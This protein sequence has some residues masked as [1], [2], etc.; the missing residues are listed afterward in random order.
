MTRLDA[1][2]FIR[3]STRID[4]DDHPFWQIG[5]VPNAAGDWFAMTGRKSVLVPLFDPDSSQSANMLLFDTDQRPEWIELCEIVEYG[6]E[7]AG[8]QSGDRHHPSEDFCGQFEIGARADTF[9]RRMLKVAFEVPVD[10]DERRD[11]AEVRAMSVERRRALSE[12]AII[13]TGAAIRKALGPSGA[14]VWEDDHALT[15]A[16]VDHRSPDRI[17]EG[18]HHLLDRPCVKDFV[19]FSFGRLLQV[20]QVGLSWIATWIDDTLRRR[21]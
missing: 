21:L 13:E 20:D 18:L 10:G 4:G 6:G 5:C 3:A 11:T 12:R 2:A 14:S 16:F 8:K 19:L 15:I 7:S 1:I 17:V 9:G